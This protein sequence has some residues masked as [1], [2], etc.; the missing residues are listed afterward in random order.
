[1]IKRFHPSLFFHAATILSLLF[2]PQALDAAEP[3]LAELQ[4]AVDAKNVDLDTLW[5]MLAAFLVFF[6]QAGFALVES[7][8]TRAK[9]AV[10]ICMKNLLDFSFASILFWAVGFGLMFSV[11]NPFTGDSGFFLHQFDIT[12]SGA[13][14]SEVISNF[15]PIKWTP[16]PIEAAFFFQLVFAG[17]TATIVSGAMAERTKLI[18]YMAYSV[19]LTALIYPISGHWI[20]GGGWL[21]ELGFWDFAGSTVVHSVGGWAALVGT[22]V[23]GP[24]IGKFGPSGSV[25]A[26]PGHNIP[27]ATLGVFILWLGWFGFNPGS[28]MALVGTDIAHIACTTNAAAAAGVVGALFLSRW[29]FGKW[30]AGM[31]LNGALAGLVA[32]TCP[33]AWVSI[34]SSLIIGLVAGLLVVL[35]VVFFDHVAKV[36]DPVGAISVHGVCG[37]WGTLSLGLFSE[38]GGDGAP[39]NGLFFKGGW[40]QLGW[41]FLGIVAVFGWTIVT[42]TVMFLAIKYTIGLRV[43]EDEEIDGLDAG[44]H[45]YAAYHNFQIVE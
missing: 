11:G 20:W 37:A 43:S 10:N 18:G 25:R 4:Q 28:T 9:N 45:G 26:I 16:V 27:L 40:E 13:D 19:V 14:G 8:F 38:G 36:D 44:E 42:A 31:A 7:G 22:I 23:L 12:L 2:L 30:D 6:M 29:C 3:T 5:T 33:C 1:M 35:S 24:R 41:Q 39:L 32:I 15:E 34:I 17:T 21:A